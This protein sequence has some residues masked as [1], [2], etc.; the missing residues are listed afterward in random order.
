MENTSCNTGRIQPFVAS[1]ESW[2]TINNT[3]HLPSPLLSVTHPTLQ[4]LLFSLTSHFSTLTTP[5][6]TRWSRS[7]S[8]SSLPSFSSASPPRWTSKHPRTKILRLPFTRGAPPAGLGVP[9][10]ASA[11]VHRK[12][13]VARLFHAASPNPPRKSGARQGSPLRLA[14]DIH[15][16]AASRQLGVRLLIKLNFSKSRNQKIR[17]NWT[18]NIEDRRKPRGQV[19]TS[20]IL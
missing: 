12:E 5:L 7:P 9:R 3:C 2:S 17:K 20:L 13:R 11:A 1:F 10:L 14:V 4:V 15:V 6:N 16:R 8:R 18:E 19:V